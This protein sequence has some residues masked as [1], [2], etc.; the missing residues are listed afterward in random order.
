MLIGLLDSLTNTLRDN[1]KK[2]DLQSA[3]ERLG[4]LQSAVEQLTAAVGEA[5]KLARSA[6][7]RAEETGSAMEAVASAMVELPKTVRH[8]TRR[9]IEAAPKPTVTV[10][11]VHHHPVIERTETPVHTIETRVEKVIENRTIPPQPRTFSLS[12]EMGRIVRAESKDVVCYVQYDRVGDPVRINVEP[13]E[14]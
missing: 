7:A 1:A 3:E 12:Y 6:V 14:K 4:S 11:E 5:E 2:S 10:E 9:A 8:E 13:K